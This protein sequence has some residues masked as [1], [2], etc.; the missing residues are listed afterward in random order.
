MSKTFH[1]LFRGVMLSLCIFIFIEIGSSDALAQEVIST[2]SVPTGPAGCY[3]DI[4]ADFQTGGAVSNYGHAVEYQFDWGD[5]NISTWGD[6]E[7]SYTYLNAG[8]YNVKARAR[9]KTHTN[10][11]SSWSAAK[12]TTITNHLFAITIN[13]PGAGTVNF[14]PIKPTGYDY[15]EAVQLLAV[16]AAGYRFHNWTGDMTY[17]PNPVYIN[18][19]RTIHVTAN[20]VTADPLVVKS[21]HAVKIPSYLTEPLIDGQLNDTAWDLVDFEYM[22]KG[23]DF[24]IWNADWTDVANNQVKWKA[25]WSATTNCLYV[26]VDVIDDV[27]G[28][29]DNRSIDPPPY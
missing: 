1:M 27:K 4:S 13:P 25:I 17:D 24:G 3:T 12:Q 16:P 14:S 6:P 19:E 23:G 21:Y 9:C 20:F 26:A 18:A 7:R 28:T 5:G 11:L 15:L 29:F 2:P 10:I 22:D 8:I